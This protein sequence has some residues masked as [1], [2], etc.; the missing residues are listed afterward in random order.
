MPAFKAPVIDRNVIDNNIN[1]KITD[2][3]LDAAIQKHAQ[4]KF[5]L[6]AAINKQE[7]LVVNDVTRDDCCMLGEWLYGDAKLKYASLHSY[8]ECLQKHR[9]FHTEAGKVAQCIN[10]KK[11]REAE[12]MMGNNTSY[13]KASKA[14]ATTIVALRKEINAIPSRQSA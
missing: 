3:D 9:A 2:I 5:K 7:N 4:W 8:D 14:V 11:Y 12:A 6:H 13:A 1:N 10:D